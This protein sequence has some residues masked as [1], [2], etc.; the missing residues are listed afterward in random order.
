[1]RQSL[2][3]LMN[4]KR[5]KAKIYQVLITSSDGEIFLFFNTTVNEKQE[6]NFGLLNLDVL[7]FG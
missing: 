6:L 2:R 1:M 5:S 4:G 7:P 3:T